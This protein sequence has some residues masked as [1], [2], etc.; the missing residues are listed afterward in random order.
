MRVNIHDKRT[1]GRE[2]YQE[3]S[4]ELKHTHPLGNIRA[5]RRVI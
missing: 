5:T 2:F 1:K 4:K 3:T